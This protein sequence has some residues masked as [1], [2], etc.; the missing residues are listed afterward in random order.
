MITQS[1]LV[2][3]I[4]PKLAPMLDESTLRH[5]MRDATDC[6]IILTPEEVAVARALILRVAGSALLNGDRGAL[7]DAGVLYNMLCSDNGLLIGMV[8][9]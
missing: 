8:K 4:G 2:N 1:T 7:V 5:C 6:D 3:L 9:R